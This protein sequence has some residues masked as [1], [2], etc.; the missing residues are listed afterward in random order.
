MGVKQMDTAGQRVI[1]TKAPSVRMTAVAKENVGRPG[2][3]RKWVGDAEGTP[4]V[5]QRQGS[6]KGGCTP[7][8]RRRSMSTTARA[9]LRAYVSTT[10]IA[11]SVGFLGWVHLQ[12]ESRAPK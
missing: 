12:I 5:G 10:A 11:P 9:R 2:P 8:R 7:R 6:R 4:W 1:L 3:L